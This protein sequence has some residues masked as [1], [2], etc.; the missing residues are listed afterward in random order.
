MFVGMKM[1]MEREKVRLSF[2]EGGNDDGRESGSGMKSGAVEE[3]EEE[4]E[5]VE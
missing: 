2:C 1:G 4:Y 5:E 3:E